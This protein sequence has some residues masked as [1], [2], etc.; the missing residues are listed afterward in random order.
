MLGQGRRFEI[1]QL[2]LVGVT[3]RQYN[4]E[5]WLQ[6][7]LHRLSTCSEVCGNQQVAT[8][9]KMSRIAKRKKIIRFDGFNADFLS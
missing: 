1:S 7:S 2:I 8:Y 5:I 4:A 6:I 9:V 3:A